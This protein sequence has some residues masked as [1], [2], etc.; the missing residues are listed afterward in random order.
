MWPIIGITNFDN[1]FQTIWQAQQEYLLST[2]QRFNAIDNSVSIDPATEGDDTS[3]KSSRLGRQSPA[4][5]P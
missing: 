1:L 3:R 2:V 4:V 5:P